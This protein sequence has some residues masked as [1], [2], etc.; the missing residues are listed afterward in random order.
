MTG[1]S[2]TEIPEADGE[3]N[4]KVNTSITETIASIGA[5]NR[6]GEAQPEQQIQPLRDPI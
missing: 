5:V 2:L 1:L 4:G 3:W 6:L